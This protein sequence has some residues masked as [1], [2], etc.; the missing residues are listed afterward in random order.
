MLMIKPLI[1][2][3]KGRKRSTF[4]LQHSMSKTACVPGYA[5]R[6]LLLSLVLLAGIVVGTAPVNARVLKIQLPPET[7]VFK[8]APGSELAGAHCLTCHSVE[9]VQTQPPKPVDF[10]AAEVKKMRDKYG[11][12]F[13]KDADDELANYLARNYGVPP[14]NSPA[15]AASAASAPATLQPTDAETLATKDGCLACHKPDGKGVAPAFPR[16]A[17]KYHEDPAAMQKIADQIHNGGAGNGGQM[18]MPAFK[19]L[20]SDEQVGVLGKWILSQ[21][22]GGK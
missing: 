7:E 19:T 13:P 2:L 8:T 5:S 20:V 10:W 12:P 9:Y 4:N 3:A 22:G 6:Y 14:T 11:A 18:P 16:V 1:F 17:A 21:Y 15:A